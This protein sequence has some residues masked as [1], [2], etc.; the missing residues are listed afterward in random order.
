LLEPISLHRK[1]VLKVVAMPLNPLKTLT[2]IKKIWISKYFPIYVDYIFVYIFR[3]LIEMIATDMQPF[4]IVNDL[5]FKRLIQK[6]N[7]RYKLPSKTHVKEKLL[8]EIYATKKQMLI[9]NLTETTNVSLTTDI[10]NSIFQ[11]KVRKCSLSDRRQ[12]LQTEP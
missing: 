4:S 2:K 7:P 1:K 9:N 12:R 10:W 6:L 8:L 5:R 3:L 11:T